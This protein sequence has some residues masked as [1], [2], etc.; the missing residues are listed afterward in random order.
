MG[1]PLGWGNLLGVE[2]QFV[3]VDKTCHSYFCL[4]HAHGYHLLG[5]HLQCWSGAAATQLY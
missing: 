3:T 1:R 2:W 4:A 5:L